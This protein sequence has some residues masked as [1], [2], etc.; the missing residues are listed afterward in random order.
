MFF[1]GFPIGDFLGFSKS[2]FVS[3]QGGKLLKFLIS[4]M[5][6]GCFEIWYICYLALY[7][8][9]YFVI[10]PNFVASPSLG[11][12]SVPRTPVPNLF[13]LQTL[14]DQVEICRVYLILHCK[15]NPSVLFRVLSSPLHRPL[16]FPSGLPSL[17]TPPSQ[18]NV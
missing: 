10:F 15:W 12:W 7:H 13:S 5:L 11:E 1:W 9:N 17:Q 8:Q 16:G 6:M 3:P 18:N 14:A 2:P 4:Q